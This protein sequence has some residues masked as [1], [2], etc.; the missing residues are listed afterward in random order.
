M[1][2]MNVK[3]CVLECLQGGVTLHMCMLK[4]LLTGICKSLHQ[5]SNCTSLLSNGNIDAV[6]FLFCKNLSKMFSLL[7]KYPC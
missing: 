2:K 5:L 4:N 7:L 6:K 3:V 1:K